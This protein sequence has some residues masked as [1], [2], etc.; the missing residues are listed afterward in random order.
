MVLTAPSTPKISRRAIPPL[1]VAVL[2]KKL[3]R[4]RVSV[5]IEADQ[6]T[7]V[8]RDEAGAEEYQLATP[9][10]SRV[11]VEEC[12]WELLSTKVQRGGA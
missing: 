8:V 12:R 10:Y 6:L 1:Q 7:V 11:L 9:L 2:A 5:S 4:E 3:T